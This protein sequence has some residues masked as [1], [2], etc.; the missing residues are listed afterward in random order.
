MS[1]IYR[2][3]GVRPVINAYGNRTLLG[4][5]TP[6]QT[7]KAAMDA[8]E[9]FYV[10]MSELY[11]A[12]GVKIADMLGIE[13]ALVTNGAAAALTYGAAGCMTGM[14]QRN[15]DKLPDSSGM[16]D[17]FIIQKQLRLRYDRCM[18]I[19]G[20]RLI[21]VGGDSGTTR[22]Q[23]EMAISDQ[24]A[25]IHCIPSADDRLGSVPLGE[26]INIAKANSVPVIV[27]ASSYVYP[28]ENLSK[29]VKMGADLVAYGGKY[30]GSVN[31][32]GLLT[33]REDLVMAARMNSFVRFEALYDSTLALGRP[34]K[35]DRQDVVGVYAALREWIN[36]DHASRFESY[37]D[38]CKEV[39]DAFRSIPHIKP[40][41]LEDDY[42]IGQWFW[43]DA[44]EA[45]KSASDVVKEL[46]DGDPGVWVVES[47]EGDKFSV[48]VPWLGNGHEHIIAERLIEI[49]G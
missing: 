29:F 21:E 43:V 6:S 15:V 27:D 31:S 20:G 26:V 40:Y 17:E 18:T 45:G 33:G 19:P 9:E 32:G 8:S 22:N 16:P 4:G 34:M 28:T 35:M 37:V 49:L 23:I 3:I 30:F 11:D 47:P 1:N 38:R 13:A 46:R 24:T 14:N 25:G 12:V 7:V 42:P 10:D 36:M 39:S 41:G 48:R 44:D 5:G 2:E